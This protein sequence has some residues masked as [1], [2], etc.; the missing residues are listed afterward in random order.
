MKFSM[1]GQDK[2]DLLIQVTTWAGLTI[3]NF[4]FGLCII[5]L[6]YENLG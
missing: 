3:L 6:Y 2:C 4:F 5:H 1:I